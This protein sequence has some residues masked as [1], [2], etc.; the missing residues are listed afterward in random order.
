MKIAKLVHWRH[1][2]SLAPPP[3]H[4]LHLLEKQNDLLDRQEANV[5]CIE[6]RIHVQTNGL[7][8][9]VNSMGGNL[10]VTQAKYIDFML[11]SLQCHNL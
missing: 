2:L 7:T 3:W 5:L 10:L 11:Q 4:W 8:L 6:K 9:L 1:L